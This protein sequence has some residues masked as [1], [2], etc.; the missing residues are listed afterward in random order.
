MCILLPCGAMYGGY[1]R[2]VSQ[3]GGIFPEE[4]A[5]T[6]SSPSSRTMSATWFERC[7]SV[8]TTCTH[9][10][11]NFSQGHHKASDILIKLHCN[12]ELDPHHQLLYMCMALSYLSLTHSDELKSLIENSAWTC[13]TQLY[14]YI[15]LRDSEHLRML[16]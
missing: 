4:T 15:A 6:L 3:C 5:L 12:C 2:M 1:A 8:W 7:C 11:H 13:Y 9:C 10:M 14:S 16:Q